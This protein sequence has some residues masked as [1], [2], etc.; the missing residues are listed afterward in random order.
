ML[1]RLDKSSWLM[2]VASLAADRSSCP[3]NRRGALLAKDF[4]ILSVGYSGSPKGLPHCT[5]EG[6]GCLIKKD[7]ASGIERCVR[8]VHAEVNA[9]INAV[10]IGTSVG[11]KGSTLFV[12]NFPC[13]SCAKFIINAGVR[14]I[15]YLGPVTD[16]EAEGILKEA[17][18]LLTEEKLKI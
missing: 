17:G 10:A 4:Y 16:S 11:T 15:H 12:T 9:L 6:V 2:A 3:R 14:E 13:M 1:D 5:D 7:V 8:V 18:I